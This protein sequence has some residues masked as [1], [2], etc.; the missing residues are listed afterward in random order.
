MP[1]SAIFKHVITKL[2]CQHEGE[3]Q[4]LT[5]EPNYD[6]FEY[7]TNWCASPVCRMTNY[8]NY[9][10]TTTTTILWPPGL[11]PGLPR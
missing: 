11:C 1:V 7:H 5:Y 9:Y 3:A 6:I 2:K 8:K 4:V 10:Y